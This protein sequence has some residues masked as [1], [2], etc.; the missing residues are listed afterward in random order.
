MCNSLSGSIILSLCPLA[1]LQVLTVNIHYSIKVYFPGGEKGFKYIWLQSDVLDSWV[2]NFVKCCCRCKWQHNCRIFTEPLGLAKTF[3]DHLAQTPCSKQGQQQNRMPRTLSSWVSSLSEK[4][5]STV[6]FFFF[7]VM[8]IWNN[9]Y[10]IAWCPFSGQH[11]EKPCLSLFLPIQYLCTLTTCPLGFLFD[12][13]NNPS[14]LSLL[15]YPS[16]L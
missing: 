14:S 11:W 2:W 1:P 4:E 7:L 15:S 9:F 16:P 10:F 3:G 8:F 6:N 13:D 12:Q 5:E